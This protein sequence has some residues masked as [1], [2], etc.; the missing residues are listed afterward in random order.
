ME[1]LTRGFRKG[2]AEEL[3]IRLRYTAETATKFGLK[4]N[5]V[6]TQN[7]EKTQARWGFLTHPD[8]PVHVNPRIYDAGFP[9]HERFRRQFTAEFVQSIENGVARA[10]VIVEGHQMGQSLTDNAHNPDGYRFHD[11]FHLACVAVLGW[12]PVTR[13]NLNRKRKSDPNIDEVEDGGRAIVT[14]EGVS[15]LVFAYAADHNSLEGVSSVDYDLL[16][17]IRIMTARFEVSVCTTGEW[18]R[19]I[20]LGHE[21]WKQVQENQGGHVRLIW[22]RDHRNISEQNQSANAIALAI[23]SDRPWLILSRMRIIPA[24]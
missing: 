3:G 13:R 21:V 17:A 15:A 7:L 22:E 23:A 4:L 9:E 6:A 18:E 1:R 5:D 14:E 11:V 16:K 2:V 19:A 20:W 8:H 12:S 24:L 10:S